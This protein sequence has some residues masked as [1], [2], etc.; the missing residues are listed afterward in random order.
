MTP[1]HA[2]EA[3]AFLGILRQQGIEAW[4]EVDDQGNYTPVITVSVE[5]MGER[6]DTRIEVLPPD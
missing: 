1:Q 3:G 6:L 2:Y 4:P 5:F